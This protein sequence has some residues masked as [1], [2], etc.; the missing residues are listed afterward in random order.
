MSGDI[1]HC[2]Y[3]YDISMNKLKAKIKK[4]IVAGI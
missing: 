4:D 3:M 2:I 1:T